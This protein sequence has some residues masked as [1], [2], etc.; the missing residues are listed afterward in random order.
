MRNAPNRKNTQ[1]KLWIAAAPAAMNA[2]RK[3]SASTMPTI[4]ANCCRCRGTFSLA[5]MMMKM[6]RLSTDRLYSVSHPAKNS[7][8]YCGPEMPQTPKPKMIAS[9]T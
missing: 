3:I 2:P 6:N 1:L 7:P 4:S 8:A 9:S 5:M